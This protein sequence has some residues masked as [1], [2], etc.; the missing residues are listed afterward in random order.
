MGFHPV[1]AFFLH[2]CLLG[3]FLKGNSI[4]L[5]AIC[6]FYI[7]PIKQQKKSDTV[8]GSIGN[9]NRL[10]VAQKDFFRLGW[11]CFRLVSYSP[12]S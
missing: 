9:A 10:V 11:E 2:L 8:E 7:A 12:G 6:I 4:I 5:S 3:L 1:T